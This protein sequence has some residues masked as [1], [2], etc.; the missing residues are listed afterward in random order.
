[1]IWILGP[2]I[3]VTPDLVIFLSARIDLLL[4]NLSEL[5]LNSKNFEKNGKRKY[6]H[7]TITRHLGVV[8]L[9][10]HLTSKWVLNTQQDRQENSNKKKQ[11]N[12]QTTILWPLFRC[13]IQ[14]PNLIVEYLFR[15]F[16]LTAECDLAPQIF[17]GN[18]LSSWSLF[19]KEFYKILKQCPT[20]SKL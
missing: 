2:Q 10:N 6:D 8:K 9:I 3:L 14:L 1:M 5:L 16:N 12:L 11:S 7:Q 17:S 4:F 20:S 18:V 15:H 13:R 19:L